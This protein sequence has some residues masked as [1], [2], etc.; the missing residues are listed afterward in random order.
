[1]IRSLW[2][3]K[4]GL[5]VQ[6]THL[7]VISNNLANGTTAGFKRVK[8]MFEDLIYQTIRQ[9]GGPTQGDA[10]SPSGLQLGAGARVAATERIHIQGALN[11]TQN[12]L[13]VAI[14]GNGFFQINLPDGTIAY[15]RDGNFTRS[16]AGEIVTQT[17]FRVAPGITIPGEATS[18]NIAQSGEVTYTVQGNPVPIQAG[19]LQLAT[20]SNPAG[21]TSIGQNLYLETA[22]S[23]N[24]QQGAPAANGIGALRQ[25]FIEA[26]NVNLAEELVSMIVA[27]RA[28]E[29][30]TRAISA[31]DDMLQRLGQM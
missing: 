24:P 31:S 3:A 30:N 9:P 12:P 29:I 16:A 18:I 23:G 13:D 5:D 28:Y 14:Y 7:D 4:T 6:Q 10:Q 11:Q 21:L 8:P 27:Q 20:F 17:G 22:A 2:I 19:Q 26:S 15:T 1:M 25:Y